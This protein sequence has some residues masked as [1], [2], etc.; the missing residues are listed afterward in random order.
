MVWKQCF[1]VSVRQNKT[2]VIIPPNNTLSKHK[3]D[4]N[5][6]VLEKLLE[7]T[8]TRAVKENQ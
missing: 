7:T 6:P 8:I 1:S 2:S 5:T 3:V 4:L